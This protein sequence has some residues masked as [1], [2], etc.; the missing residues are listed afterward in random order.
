MSDATVT[1]SA[2]AV[3][4]PPPLLDQVRQQA[5]ARSHNAGTA[6]AFVTWIRQFILFHDKRH[7][8]ELALVEIGQFLDHVVRTTTTSLLSANGART[9][10][11]FLYDEVLRLDLGE[12]P[13]PRQPRA[14]P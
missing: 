4:S 3:A 5:L 14:T 12:L 1:V 2:T 13:W 8:R 9:A 11:E 6:H 7:P 10:L